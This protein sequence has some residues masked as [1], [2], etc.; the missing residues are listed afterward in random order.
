MKPDEAVLVNVIRLPRIIP[1]YSLTPEGVAAL[2]AAE[3][4]RAV[5]VEARELAMR[6]RNEG[7]VV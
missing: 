4:A 5:A 6:R 3:R 2:D 1:S 7:K